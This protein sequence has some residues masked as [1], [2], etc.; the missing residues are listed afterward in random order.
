MDW[1]VGLWYRVRMKHMITLQSTE[2]S[3]QTYIILVIKITFYKARLS[4]LNIK[5]YKEQYN[6]SEK[7]LVLSYVTSF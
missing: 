3:F 4:F 1:G 2:F 5:T 6:L 7:G